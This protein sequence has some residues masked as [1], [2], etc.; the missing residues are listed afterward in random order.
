MEEILK[1]GHLSLALKYGFPEEEIVKNCEKLPFNEQTVAYFVDNVGKFT[2]GNISKMHKGFFI[3]YNFMRTKTVVCEISENDD[4]SSIIFYCLYCL[5]LEEAKLHIP[6]I[7]ANRDAD[8]YQEICEGNRSILEDTINNDFLEPIEGLLSYSYNKDFFL[9]YKKIYQRVKFLKQEAPL[10]YNKVAY[11]YYKNMLEKF[12]MLYTIRQKFKDIIC[13]TSMS[14]LE[15][16]LNCLHTEARDYILGLPP[17]SNLN[18]K[19]PSNIDAHCSWVRERIQETIPK[20]NF[21]GEKLEIVNTEN[22]FY[23]DV[24]ENSYMDILPFVSGKHCYLFTR[25]EFSPLLSQ[26]KNFYTNEELPLSFLI[27]IRQRILYVYKI[28]ADMLPVKLG[29]VKEMLTELEKK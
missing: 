27:T 20:V 16:N 4:C 5:D 8:K 23:E 25:K 21:L 28:I 1:Y 10:Y 7:I 22:I 17:G 2:M 11:P 3:L 12:C 19:N 15:C 6:F 13:E 29:T 9:A 24:F 26:G 14:P 18:T